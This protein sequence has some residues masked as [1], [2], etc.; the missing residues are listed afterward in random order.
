MKIFFSFI[1]L[2]GFVFTLPVNAQ[3]NVITQNI[4]P[5]TLP[6]NAVRVPVLKILV[7]AVDQVRILESV[8]LRLS[9]LIDTSDIGRVWIEMS[10]G[11]KSFSRSFGTDYQVT[12]PFRSKVIVPDGED[13]DLYVVLNM[14]ARAA[15]SFQVTV[16]N[17]NFS[18]FQVTKP[19]P[20]YKNI[21]RRNY[22]RNS[23][24]NRSIFQSK[25]AKVNK[26]SLV[27]KNSKC[28]RV[29]K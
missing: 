21:Q 26:F 12:L 22:R 18:D 27:C 17:V 10:N 6:R 16:K 20:V 5:K 28:Q 13:I 7:P 15:R 19:S 4:T 1:L 29:Y 14:Q 2:L 25:S 24:F 3:I 11:K 23:H 9:G 8:D